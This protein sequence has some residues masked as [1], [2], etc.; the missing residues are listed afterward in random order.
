MHYL[1]RRERKILKNP[2]DNIPSKRARILANFINP[3]PTTPNFEILD[4]NPKTPKALYIESR[5]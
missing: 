2:G 1:S 3:N 4:S 5:V